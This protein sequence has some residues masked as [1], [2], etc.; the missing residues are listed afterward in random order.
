MQ[1][2]GW[3]GVVPQQAGAMPVPV[4]AYGAAPY[5][6]YPVA[7]YGAY[8]YGGAMPVPAPAMQPV[9]PASIPDDTRSRHSRRSRHTSRSRQS[10]RSRSGERRSSRRERRRSQQ[11]DRSSRSKSS[12]Q[13]RLTKNPGR[14]GT[15]A[16]D[17]EGV[18]GK[19]DRGFCRLD[20]LQKNQLLAISGPLQPSIRPS[21]RTKL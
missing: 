14:F 17:G 7:A 21:R 20:Q 12:G 8:P 13:S 19:H 2:G 4:Q 18:A 15:K 3:Q 10:R 9:P 11:T 16:N 6:G 5:G 1:A